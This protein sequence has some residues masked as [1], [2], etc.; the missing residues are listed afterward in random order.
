[1]FFDFTVISLTFNKDGVYRVIPAVNSPI[2]VIADITLPADNS[3]WLWW[4]SVK[5][6]LSGLLEKLGAWGV[7]ILSVVI[8]TLILILELKLLSAFGE[9]KNNAARAIF[10]IL[11]LAL[12]A[13]LD[14]MAVNF[15]IETINGL[16]G[17]V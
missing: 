1:M 2:D 7:L 15:V 8:G 17:L 3:F 13:F 16:G 14:Y 12:F 4:D 5:D 10:V 6:W 9:I 11:F